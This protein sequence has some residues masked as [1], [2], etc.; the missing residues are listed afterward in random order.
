M[1]RSPDQGA[2]V[3]RHLRTR[4]RVDMARARRRAVMGA[5]DPRNR[6]DMAAGHLHSKMVMDGAMAARLLREGRISMVLRRR[7]GSLMAVHRREGMRR[8][9]LGSV[10]LYFR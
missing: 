8:D 4:I 6:A 10:I 7:V 9:R 2:T 3:H 5:R 1:A